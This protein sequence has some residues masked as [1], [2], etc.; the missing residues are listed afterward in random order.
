MGRDE[1]FMLTLRERDE[2]EILA[3]EGEARRQN[4]ENSEIVTQDRYK[5]KHKEFSDIYQ[6][7]SQSDDFVTLYTQNT[8]VHTY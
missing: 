4:S 3:E 6:S 8:V 7:Q 1:L 5:K 2:T